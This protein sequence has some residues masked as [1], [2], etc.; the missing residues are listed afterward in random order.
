MRNRIADFVRPN[1]EYLKIGKPEIRVVSGDS[2][3]LEA[4][5]ITVRKNV[6]D[7]YFDAQGNFL[8]SV[9]GVLSFE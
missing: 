3:K 2:G 1:A 9:N 4:Y 6:P 7:A 8:F 5:A